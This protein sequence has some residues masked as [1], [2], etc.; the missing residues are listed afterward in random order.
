MTYDRR[1]VGV[2][3]SLWATGI[4]LVLATCVMIDHYIKNIRNIGYL[5]AQRR[6]Q[7]LILSPI[8]IAWPSWVIL[9]LG[10]G[11]GILEYVGDMFKGIALFI[12]IDYSIRLVG[13]DRDENQSEYSPARAEG[14]FIRL[15]KVR[16][17]CG[18]LG[19]T[20]LKNQEDVSWF[21][22]KIRIAAFQYC[23]VLFC[24]LVVSIIL[25]L[26]SG[27]YLRY[28][29]MDPGYGYFWISMFKVITS[30]IALYQV[31]VF[32]K[33]VSAIPEMRKINVNFKF[34]TII[35][36]FI[37]TQ[38]QFPAIGGLSRISG[39]SNEDSRSDITSYTSNLLLC[40]EMIAMSFMQTAVF[41]IND[42]KNNPFKVDLEE[43][44]RD[45]I[46]TSS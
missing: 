44:F 2:G 33:N 32:S 21:L 13:W 46:L 42:Y 39:F 41:N 6:L 8:I 27:D 16:N 43:K 18:C 36:G 29:N 20:Q 14:C 37:V 30:T 1:D 9:V 12:F 38:Y 15:V 35:V 4:S 28:G 31:Y 11:A 45:R 7:F 34:F 23:I 10:T 40:I 3:G 25:K 17:I 26:I 22:N 5:E 19:S 24:L